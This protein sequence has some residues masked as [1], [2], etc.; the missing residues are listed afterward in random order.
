[1]IFQLFCVNCIF[2]ITK[3]PHV[4]PQNFFWY[5]LAPLK[6]THLSNFTVSKI[7]Q[8]RHCI[9]C[10]ESAGVLTGQSF[11]P[12][13]TTTNDNND[14]QLQ[15]TTEALDGHFPPSGKF[16]EK[17]LNL[18]LKSQIRKRHGRSHHLVPFP[19]SPYAACQ[20]AFRTFSSAPNQSEGLF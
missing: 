18:K 4:R 17:Q 13:I 9:V 7:G 3:T 10:D 16:I 20:T 8:N 14:K 11:C 1:M 12:C 5:F 15:K 2:W 6:M 19:I